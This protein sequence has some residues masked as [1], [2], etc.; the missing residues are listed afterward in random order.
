MAIGDIAA[1]SHL[2]EAD[3]ETLGNELDSIR[4]DIEE[5][6]GTTDAAYIRRTIT[7]QRTLDLAARLIIACS[8]SRA[9]WALG[10]A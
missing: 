6:L 2:S 5:S 7:F 8:K 10:T 9:G 3:I 4:F 1:Y